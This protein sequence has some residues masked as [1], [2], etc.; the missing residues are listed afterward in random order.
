MI[1]FLLVIKRGLNKRC[2]QCGQGQLFTSW[3]AVADRCSSCG[4]ELKQREGDCWFFIYM[5]TAFFTGLI[6]AG[7]FLFVPSNI[8]V[9][10]VAVGLAGVGFIVL[11]LP[12]RK[13]IAFAID[14][15]SENNEKKP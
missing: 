13:G 14:Y 4:Y 11:T 7:M 15:L 12:I 1:W 10:Q 9:G 8:L 2:P 3:N 6:V 5:S